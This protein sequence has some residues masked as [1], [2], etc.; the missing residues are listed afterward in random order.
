MPIPLLLERDEQAKK[1]SVEYGFI[2]IY[3]V[4][5]NLHSQMFTFTAFKSFN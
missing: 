4:G 1:C 2:S 5:D 3:N